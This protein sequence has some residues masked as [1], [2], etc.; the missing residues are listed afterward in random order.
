MAE[1]AAR[2]PRAGVAAD[3]SSEF[4]YEFRGV[5][6]LGRSH[7]KNRLMSKAKSLFPI[8]LRDILRKPR[9][10]LLLDVSAVDQI[11]IRLRDRA[12]LWCR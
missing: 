8:L 11:P 6:T 1:I 7:R 12:L 9:C 10:N 2:H 5:G 4:S 3:H